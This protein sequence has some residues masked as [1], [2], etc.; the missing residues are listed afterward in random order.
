MAGT[1]EGPRGRRS[2]LASTP[3]P[4]VRG[5]MNGVESVRIVT[6]KAAK[7]RLRARQAPA[8]RILRAVVM[9]VFYLIVTAGAFSMLLP[10][11]WMATTG[12]KVDREI[13]TYPPTWVPT[14]LDFS[15]FRKAITSGNFGRAF[16]NS[17]I[18]GVTL[19]LSNV[20]LAA[21]TGYAFARLNFPGRQLLFVLVLATM[22][23]PYQVTIIPLFVMVKNVPLFGGNDILGA[24]GIG[25][26]NSWWGLIVP[27]AVGA[28]GIFMMRQ[29]F[30]VLPPDLEDAARID[31]AG[32]WR[33]FWQIMTPLTWPALAT[34]SLFSFQG[35]W[36]AFYWPLLITTSRD[37]Q[38]LQL[39]LRVFRNQFTTDWGALMAGATVAT[40]PMIAVFLVGQRFFTR[41]IAMTG[42]KG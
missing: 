19:V 2:G 33:I 32:E 16:V 7:A 25:W 20:G 26:M 11:Y 37:M 24:G 27:N 36:N 28:F 39:A 15:H 14:A 9:L 17:G 41:G 4:R 38:T 23:V 18:L 31:G 5:R 8:A 30:L 29:F 10:F 22:M 12:I 42:I 21:L 40:V 3:W 13:L 6:P 34:L 1:S 35:G